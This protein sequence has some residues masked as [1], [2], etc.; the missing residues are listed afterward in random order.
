VTHHWVTDHSVTGHWQTRHWVTGLSVTRHWQT[1]VSVTGLRNIRNG[2]Y[3][4]IVKT[5]G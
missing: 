4:E 1:G 5:A 3:A 2:L